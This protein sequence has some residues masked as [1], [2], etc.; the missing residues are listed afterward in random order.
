MLQT[1]SSAS[2]RTLLKATLGTLGF[3]GALLAAPAAHAQ[4]VNSTPKI[5]A[6]NPANTLTGTG[7]AVATAI[8]GFSG[9]G[10][11]DFNGK[12]TSL[13]MSYSATTAGSYEIVIVYESQYDPKVG[14]LSVNGGA[15]NPVYFNSTK[16]AGG[17]KKTTSR[18]ILLTAGANT[19]TIS[20]NDY[21][22]F[23]ID[24]VQIAAVAATPAFLLPLRP[25]G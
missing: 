10:Y 1:Y 12:P 8:T 21:G 5:E 20:D 15:K 9:T 22:Y 18:R 13:T 19:I 24:Y 17:F 4:V 14:A 25:A 7:I 16:A 11:V 6:E 2:T 3:C 23:G